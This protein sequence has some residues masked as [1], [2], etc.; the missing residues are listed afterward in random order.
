MKKDAGVA[1]PSKP[2]V[3]ALIMLLVSL[4]TLLLAYFLRGQLVGMQG[5]EGSLL[6]YLLFPLLALGLVVLA[7]FV[8]AVM[9][10]LR[11]P[12]FDRLKWGRS[13]IPW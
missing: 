13:A 1:G 4:G 3:V 7:S 12:L 11:R 8:L 2:F 6:P 5:D 10:A 9:F